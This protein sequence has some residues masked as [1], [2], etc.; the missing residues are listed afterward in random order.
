MISTD[1]ARI[2]IDT[3]NQI[4]SDRMDEGPTLEFKETLPDR[5]DKG[6]VEFL[7]DAA[8]MA[9]SFGGDIVYGIGEAEGV[10]ATI[11]PIQGESYDDASRRLGQMLDSGIEPRLQDVQMK[12]VDVDGGYVVVMR[13]GSSQI[14]PHRTVRNGQHRFPVRNSGYT[15]DMSYDQLRTAFDRSA[16]LAERARSFRSERLKAIATLKYGTTPQPTSVVVH[17][18]P[19]GGMGARNVIDIRKA[20][21]NHLELEGP[22]WMGTTRTYNLD[23]LLVSEPHGQLEPAYTQLYR[24]GAIETKRGGLSNLH[25]GVDYI[26]AALLT[27]FTRF[28]IGMALGATAKFGSSGG[29]LVGVTVFDVHGK[30][31]HV[32]MMFDLH[33]SARSDRSTLEL[34]EVWVED[35]SKLDLDVVARPILDTLWQCFGIEACQFYEQD[36]TF[37]AQKRFG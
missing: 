35:V 14:G 6:I 22:K 9:N 30:T 8:G 37:N 33:Y 23:G 1:F 3:L 11:T 28:M 18:L 10:A 27:Q 13:V 21:A 5:S 29:A 12:G 16:S 34:P 4:V 36:G 26:S 25:Q 19:L 7:K 20:H 15:A 2:D 31:F 24:S 17:V 32:G